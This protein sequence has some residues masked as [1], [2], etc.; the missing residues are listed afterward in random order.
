MQVRARAELVSIDG[1]K[2]KFKVQAWDESE[3]IGEADHDRIVI[4][5]SRFMTRVNEKGKK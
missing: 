3:Q 2:L 5:E 4:D 1:R